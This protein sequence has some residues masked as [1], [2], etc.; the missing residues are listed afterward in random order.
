MPSNSLQYIQQAKHNLEFLRIAYL[1]QRFDDWCVTVSFYATVHIVEYAITAATPLKYQGT[2]L[3]KKLMSSSELPAVAGAQNL[4]P[5]ANMTWD[6]VSPHKLRKLL[7]QSNFSDI[8][9]EYALLYD[10][11]RAARYECYKFDR[12]EF[13][14]LIKDPLKKIVDWANSKYGAG[15]VLDLSTPS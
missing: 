9:N 8:E 1:Q 10:K 2:V 13:D 6:H 3:K 12:T 11:S 4:P 15:L 14:I 5:P 7:V